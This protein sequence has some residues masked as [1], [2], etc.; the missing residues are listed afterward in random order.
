MMFN[1]A[2]VYELAA[3]KPLVEPLLRQVPFGTPEHIEVKRLLALLEW[4]LPVDEEHIPDN[5]LIREFIGRSIL[6]DFKLWKKY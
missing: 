2:L 1:S 6:E 3:Y 5:S 4:F